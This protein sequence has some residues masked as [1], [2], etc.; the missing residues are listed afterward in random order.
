MG[1]QITPSI[2]N[3]DLS[4]LNDEIKR[5][6]S[7]DAIHLD[8][9]DNRFVPNLTFGLPVVEAMAA[10]CPVV[11]ARGSGSDE[12]VG[13]AGAHVDADDPAEAAREIVKL[14][15]N[16]S[17]REALR[18]MGPARAAEFSCE[19]MGQGYITSWRRALGRE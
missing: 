2:L 12:L 9:M 7:A 10:G 4:R 1:I 14:L 8:V 6:P 19:A 3:A 5:I 17:H 13:D 18:A 16:P 15:D 11:V